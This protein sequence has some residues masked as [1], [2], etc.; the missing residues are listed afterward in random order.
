M[1]C[2]VETRTHTDVHASGPWPRCKLARAC[3]ASRL[4]LAGAD[5]TEEALCTRVSCLHMHTRVCVSYTQVRG[6]DFSSYLA[7]L[8]T[9]RELMIM[10]RDARWLGRKRKR[11]V[12]AA[13]CLEPPGAIV[14]GK[15][16]K[17]SPCGFTADALHD[18]AR[19][20]CWQGWAAVQ[21]RGCTTNCRPWGAH[22]Q[23][24]TPFRRCRR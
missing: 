24:E 4:V 14:R 11:I 8:S 9:P 12:A 16:T 23:P 3:A 18:W 21:Q 17:R 15:A 13:V 22:R 6:E 20:V 2:S 10:V 1:L 5:G 7:K 19:G